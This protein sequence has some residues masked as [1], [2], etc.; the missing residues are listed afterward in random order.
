MMNINEK[1]TDTETVSLPSPTLKRRPT[2]QATEQCALEQGF[3]PLV[4]RVLANRPVLKDKP[5]KDVVLASLGQLDHPAVLAGM[6]KAAERV[7]QAIMDSSELILVTDFDSDG[8]TANAVLTTSL[9]QFFNHPETAIKRY[10]GHRLNDGYGLT[11]GICDR[12]LAESTSGS[13][14][15]TADHGSSDED[16][17]TQLAAA[18]I[19]VIVSDHHE[20]PIDNYPVSAYAFINPQRPDCQYPDKTIAGCMVAFLLMTQV[21][22]LLI[23]RKHL[24]PSTP[25][26]SSLLDFV[27]LGTVADC[28]SL[29][30][31]ANNRAVV[32]YGLKKIKERA[33]PAW[34]AYLDHRKYNDPV[35]SETLAFYIGPL[36]NARSRMDE[37]MAGLHYL[38]SDTDPVAADY[39]ATLNMENAK[40]KSVERELTERAL[41]IAAEQVNA[42]RLGLAIFLDPSHPGVHGITSSRVREAT[43]R[44]VIMLSRSSNDPELVTGSARGVDGKFHVREALQWISEQSPDLYKA[45]GGHKGAAGCSLPYARLDEFVDLFDQAVRQQLTAND[46]GPIILTDGE[47]AISEINLDT[48]DQLDAIEPFGR[49]FE[50]PV[51]EADFTVNHAKWIGDGTH[52]VL[53]LKNGP[54]VFRAIWFG[55][56]KDESMESPV[57]LGEVRHFAFEI[58]DNVY[59]DQRSVQLR[60]VH[61]V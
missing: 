52:L 55:A 26:L 8:L 15:I 38:L 43:G 54:Q 35:R 12:I 1:V 41:M 5:L 23:E 44:P 36:L 16:R 51:F 28:V 61:A 31:S 29:A 37:P 7:A 40:R 27:S 13:L 21:R 14:V 32:R 39:L 11:Q 22:A 56:R 6:D 46:V 48:V 18:G 34:R 17:I 49:E 25:S 53:F 19:D 9:I 60:I 30:R 58:R 3:S 24:P 57:N 33:R 20:I 45:Y 47:V 59:R 50:Y 10:I 42:G 2:D 4:A